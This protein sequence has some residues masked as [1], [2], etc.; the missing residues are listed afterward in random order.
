MLDKKKT[1]REQLKGALRADMKASQGSR[2]ARLQGVVY[3]TEVKGISIS[4]TRQ[5]DGKYSVRYGRIVRTNM[6]ADTAAAELGAAIMFALNGG[7]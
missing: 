3:S 6:D 1:L 7:K 4:L 2:T 5:S